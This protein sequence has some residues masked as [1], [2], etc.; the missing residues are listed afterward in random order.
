M[1]PAGKQTVDEITVVIDN[2]TYDVKLSHEVTI[3]QPTHPYRATYSSTDN[4]GDTLPTTPSTMYAT[5]NADGTFTVTLAGSQTWTTDHSSSV[6]GT[7]AAVGT[8]TTRTVYTETNGQWITVGCTPTYVYDYVKYTETKTTYQA[9]SSKTTWTNTHTITGWNV[10]G[11]TYEPGATV[12]I[13]GNVTVTA[14][15]SVTEGEKTTTNTTATYYTY[16]YTQTASATKQTSVPS[17]YGT[18]VDS[19]LLYTSPSPRD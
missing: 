19:C 9:Q 2:V 1:Y 3:N 12:T 15:V 13:S 5:P 8:P 18:K 10:N 7:F 11:T 6:D 14:V 4:N 16:T 17:G